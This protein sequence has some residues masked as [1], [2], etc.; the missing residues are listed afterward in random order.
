[1]LVVK[2]EVV[3]VVKHSVDVDDVRQVDVDVTMLCVVQVPPVVIVV[4]I[5]TAVIELLFI[6]N[7]AY[8][9]EY[10]KDIVIPPVPERVVK[11]ALDV[12]DG[13]LVVMVFALVDGTTVVVFNFV[14][15]TVST[16]VPRTVKY[17]IVIA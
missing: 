17:V 4:T 3:D 5:A 6:I 15:V 2:Q 10:D 8:V 9:I 12:T 14:V 7:S 16:R 1:M 11:V 13:V